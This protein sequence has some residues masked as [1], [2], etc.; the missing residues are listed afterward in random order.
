MHKTGNRA[1]FPLFLLFSPQ[2]ISDRH[3]FSAEILGCHSVRR[4]E[5]SEIGRCSVAVFRC[6]CDSNENR[7]GST[8]GLCGALDEIRIAGRYHA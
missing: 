1:G 7:N 5:D 4:S 2:V 8:I 3:L 6:F